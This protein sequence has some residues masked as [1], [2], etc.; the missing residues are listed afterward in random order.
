MLISIVPKSSITAILSRLKDQQQVFQN[1]NIAMMQQMQRNTTAGDVFGSNSAYAVQFHEGVEEI[2]E[3]ELLNE[4]DSAK[5][6]EEAKKIAVG[7]AAA[8]FMKKLRKKEEDTSETDTANSKNVLNLGGVTETEVEDSKSVLKN[9]VNPDINKEAKIVDPSS[10]KFPVDSQDSKDDNLRSSSSDIVNKI[11]SPK[12]KYPKK[13]IELDLMEE[14]DNYADDHGDGTFRSQGSNADDADKLFALDVPPSPPSPSAVGAAHFDVA[15]LN[16]QVKSK[17][18]FKEWTRNFKHAVS[19]IQNKSLKYPSLV[20]GWVI[21]RLTVSVLILLG[22]MGGTIYV[23]FTALQQTQ[24]IGNQLILSSYR[25]SHLLSMEYFV[26]QF[27]FLDNYKT[28]STNYVNSEATSP[29]FNDLSHLLNDQGIMKGIIT[30]SID[31]F[32]MIDS[33]LR[34]YSATKIS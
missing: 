16:T 8:M 12:A 32:H 9:S 18:E 26:M 5:E 27:I 25:T 33:R 14:R 29:V 31:Y 6:R 7:N 2:D 34:F 23:S 20:N 1:E 10:V 15:E 30:R 4:V 11:K 28:I 21:G 3:D 24:V 22:L 19:E 13:D 17:T